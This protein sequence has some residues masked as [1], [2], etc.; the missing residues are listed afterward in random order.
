MDNSFIIYR[1]VHI[2]KDVSFS[3][4]LLCCQISEG[5]EAWGVS[6]ISRLRLEISP[7]GNGQHSQH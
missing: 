7:V 2:M 5:G 3:F 6:G 1:P 4:P